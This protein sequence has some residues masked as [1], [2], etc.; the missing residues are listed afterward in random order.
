VIE[1]G[2][3]FRVCEGCGK[4]TGGGGGKP[5]SESDITFVKNERGY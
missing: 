4:T 3:E 2:E 5:M 1:H